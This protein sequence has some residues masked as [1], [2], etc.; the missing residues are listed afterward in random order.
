MHSHAPATGGAAPLMAVPP[1]AF[2]VG[3]WYVA[4]DLNQVSR[5]GRMLHVRPQLMD[6]LVYLAR[7][8]GRTVSRD[9]LQA[10]VWPRQPF[11]TLSA[12]PRCIAELR[13]TLGDCATGPTLIQTVPK[14]GYRLIAPVRAIEERPAGPRVA[15]P[16]ADAGAGASPSTD[17]RIAA[18]PVSA[19]GA[20]WIVR[21]RA[22]LSYALDAAYNRLR[23]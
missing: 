19:S 7:N 17:A 3:D 2:V 14:R 8:R 5:D 10:H 13:Q 11:I 22:A 6:L 1:S 18:G 12:L 21:A 9:E 16:A 4:P 20:S 15:A 23:A